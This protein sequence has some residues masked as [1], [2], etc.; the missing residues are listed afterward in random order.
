MN[1]NLENCLY[2]SGLTAQGCT[3]IPAK[4]VAASIWKIME[5]VANK[6]AEEKRENLKAVMLDQF[7]MVMFNGPKEKEKNGD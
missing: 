7:G 6:Y 4:E 1:D 3:I 5:E 2:K